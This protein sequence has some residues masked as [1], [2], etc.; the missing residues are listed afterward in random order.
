MTVIGPGADT[1]IGI[2][3][4]DGAYNVGIDALRLGPPCHAG[5]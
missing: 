5:Q 2:S 4:S 3:V 1:A